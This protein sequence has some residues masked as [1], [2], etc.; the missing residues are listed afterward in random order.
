[1]LDGVVGINCCRVDRT[2]LLVTILF[3]KTGDFMARWIQASPADRAT[4]GV[5]H[6]VV[7]M[8]NT[9]AR[10]TA[11]PVTPPPHFGEPHTVEE[12]L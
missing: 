1:M 4:A 9:L 2:I 10:A 7:P 11:R 8:L 5:P 12:V 3:S 6:Q